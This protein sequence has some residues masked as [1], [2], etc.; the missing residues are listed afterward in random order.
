[1]TILPELEQ[2]LVA[3]AAQRRARRMPWPRQFGLTAAGAAATV[4]VVAAV[5]AL[6]GIKHER[7]VAPVHRPS[8]VVQRLAT[9]YAVFARP[10]GANDRLPH[11]YLSPTSH[12]FR[13]ITME[14]DQARLVADTAAARGFVVPATNRSG[15][16]FVCTLIVLAGDRRGGGA[17]WSLAERDGARRPPRART[18]VRGESVVLYLLPDGVDRVEVLLQDRRSRSVPVTSNGALIGPTSSPQSASW[19]DAQGR[20]HT[21]SIL[22]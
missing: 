9:T 1:M 22:E 7:D 12:P 5:A 21:I 2:S 16:P 14:V 15:A 4:V 18:T 6:S 20:R 8:A 3:A 19:I 17:C 13:G 11:H 10:H